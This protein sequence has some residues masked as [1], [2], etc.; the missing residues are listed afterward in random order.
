[1][2]E[3]KAPSDPIPF[4]HDLPR[5]AWDRADFCPATPF[6]VLGYQRSGTNLL[7]GALFN[8]RPA[9]IMHNELFD[10]R[11]IWSYYKYVRPTIN[12]KII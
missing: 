1:M 8:L 9:V 4:A 6:V 12:P 11:H 3:P 7:C 10:G 5:I 2:S